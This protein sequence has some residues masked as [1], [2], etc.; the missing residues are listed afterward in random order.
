MKR[1][2]LMTGLPLSLMFGVTSPG[3]ASGDPVK[4]SWNAIRSAISSFYSA[5]ASLF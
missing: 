2:S 5:I 3:Y 4:F 1:S